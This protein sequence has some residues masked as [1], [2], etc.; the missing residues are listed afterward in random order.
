MCEKREHI[1]LWWHRKLP[2]LG[3]PQFFFIYIILFMKGLVTLYTCH[4]IQLCHNNSYDNF[5]AIMY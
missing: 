4:S 3:P 5:M 1:V 2:P